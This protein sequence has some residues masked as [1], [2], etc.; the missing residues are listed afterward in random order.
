MSKDKISEKTILKIREWV[1]Q[2]TFLLFM[3][4]KM[5]ISLSESDEIAKDMIYEHSDFIDEILS[6]EDVEMENG[7]I[8][9][10]LGHVAIETVVWFQISKGEPSEAKE[11]YLILLNE[12]V[13]AHTARHAVGAVL[14]ELIWWGMKE[15]NKGKKPPKELGDPNILYVKGLR[16]LIRQKTNHPFFKTR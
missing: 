15:I 13:D 7:E 9:N 8:M 4:E 1:R 16:K 3:S 10:P 12:G 5:G 6:G 11:A 14:V 2:H